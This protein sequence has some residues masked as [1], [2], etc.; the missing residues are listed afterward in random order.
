MMKPNSA[1][2]DLEISVVTAGTSVLAKALELENCFNQAKKEMV[3]PV[4]PL[5]PYSV[6]MGGISLGAG[7]HAGY[8][9]Y[10]QCIN[11]GYS[12]EAALGQSLLV[13][14]F[15]TVAMGTMFSLPPIMHIGGEAINKYVS[16]S[17]P[18]KLDK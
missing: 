13:G 12:T 16:S 7:A 18:S 9:T 11:S 8:S 2:R 17:N 6:V 15:M 10:E 1:L 3:G 14:A 4:I 5:K